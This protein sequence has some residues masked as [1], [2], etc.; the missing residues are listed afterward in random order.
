MHSKALV[1][2]TVMVAVAA[3]GSVV[4]AAQAQ[5][6]TRVAQRQAHRA[7]RHLTVVERAA[8]DTVVDLGPKGDSLGDQLT[9]A[10]TVYDRTNSHRVG[11]DQGSCVRTVVGKAWECSYTTILA[12]GSLVVTGPF[13]DTRDSVLAITG[14]TGSYSRARGVL[15][16]HARNAQGSAFT[17]RFV[18]Q[19]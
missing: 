11:R 6:D 16:L 17:F 12:H 14:G 15:H 9:F 2:S 19:D 7:A 5:P 18:I 13:Y 1:V 10:N 3:G 8:S 4:G